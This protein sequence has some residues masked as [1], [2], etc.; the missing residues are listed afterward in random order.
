MCQVNQHKLLLFNYSIGQVGLP[1]VLLSICGEVGYPATIILGAWSVD[2]LTGDVLDN[3]R[4]RRYRFAALVQLQ[5]AIVAQT[6]VSLPPKALGRV[7]C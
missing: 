2:I 4:C 3:T 6:G 5:K 1:C 7:G